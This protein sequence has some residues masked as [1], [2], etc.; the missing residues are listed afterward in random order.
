ML[1]KKLL[2]LQNDYPE[3]NKEFVVKKIQSLRGSFRKELK[4]ALISK[5]SGIEADEIYVPSLWCYNLLFFTEGQELAT[6]S[7]S[8]MVDSVILIEEE[9]MEENEKSGLREERLRWSAADWKLQQPLLLSSTATAAA[10]R[11]HRHHRQGYDGC[12]RR[13]QRAVRDYST[14]SMPRSVHSVIGSG[15]CHRIDDDGLQQSSIRNKKIVGAY[16]SS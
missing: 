9:N 2:F 3:A 15:D 8:N 1:T 14:R 12:A 7:L 6:D 13:S 11:L 10:A 16:A 5:C 4:K